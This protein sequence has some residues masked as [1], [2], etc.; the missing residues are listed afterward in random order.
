MDKLKG[1]QCVGPLSG[2]SEPCLK[3]LGHMTKE[4]LK[5]KFFKDSCKIMWDLKDLK[6]FKNI[7]ANVLNIKHVYH[8]YINNLTLYSVLCWSTFGSKYSLV[9]SWVWRYKLGTTG[10]RGVS[11]ICRCRSSKALLGWMGSVAPQLFSGFFRDISSGSSPDSGWAIQRLVPKPLMHCLG[12][13]LRVVVLLVNLSCWWTFSP[14]WGSERSG[15]SF[16]WGSL[17]TLLRS[18]FPQSWLV[19]QSL[20]LKNIPKA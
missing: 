3:S 12:C 17:C 8:I 9:S 6:F 11:P 20:P 10:Y 4:L 7:F 14:V 19:S 18:S 2:H 5:F 15:A 13:E 16:N 1:V